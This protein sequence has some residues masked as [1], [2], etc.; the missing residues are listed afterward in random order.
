MLVYPTSMFNIFYSDSGIPFLL[1]SGNKK[2]SK[3][4]ISDTGAESHCCPETPKLL[5]SQP[6]PKAAGLK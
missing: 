4:S 5:V 2:M 6:R 1:H 3:N